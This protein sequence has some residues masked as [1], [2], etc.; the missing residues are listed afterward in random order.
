VLRVGF[1]GRLERLKG[2][3]LAVRAIAAVARRGRPAELIIAGDSFDGF[4]ADVVEPLIRETGVVVRWVQLAEQDVAAFLRGCD[5]LL[6]PSRYD[7]FPCAAIEALASGVP[8]ITTSRSGVSERFTADEGLLA[9]SLADE[10]GFAEAAADA[11]LDDDWLL[12]AATRGPGRVRDVLSVERL[13]GE[14]L[15]VYDEALRHS[16]PW[17]AAAAEADA[18]RE[19]SRHALAHVQAAPQLDAEGTVTLAFA[20]ELM[21]RPDLLAAYAQ[22]A[23]G[24]ETS[25]LVAITDDEPGVLADAFV[26]LLHELGLDSDGGPDIVLHGPVHDRGEA[27]APRLDAVLSEQRVPYALGR[28]PRL[29]ANTGTAT[30][31]AALQSAA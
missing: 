25:T 13:G 6:L 21:Q 2:A 8:V 16:R 11:L 26:A 14:L 30:T 5:C 1:V 22:A 9:L 20:D 18:L 3:D 31:F 10:A 17:K 23:V 12:G 4:R 15:D 19:A 7:S 24:G 29:R 27:L 28:V